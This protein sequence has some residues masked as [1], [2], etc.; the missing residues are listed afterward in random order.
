MTDKDELLQQQLYALENG[1]P[2]GSVV[3]GLPEQDQDLAPLISL[4]AA[5]REIPHPDLLLEQSQAQQQQIAA[6]VARPSNNHRNTNPTRQKKTTWGRWGWTIVPALA[7]AGVVMLCFVA[8]LAGV[9]LWLGGPPNARAATLMDAHGQIEVASSAVS[10]DWRSVTTGERVRAGQRLR[11]HDASG[12]TLLFFD[13]TRTTVGSDADVTLTKLGGGWGNVLKVTLTQNG[14][15]TNHSVVPLRGKNSSFL[16]LTPSGS[17]S[18]H[19]TTFNVDV[20]SNGRSRF[21]V[22]TGTVLVSNADAQVS[23][24]AGQATAAQ[25]GQKPEKPAYRFSLAGLVTAN[26]GTTWVVSGVPFTVTPDTEIRGNPQVSSRV[27]VKGRILES[28]VWVADQIEPVEDDQQASSFT[29]TV[30]AISGDTWQVDGWTVLANRITD[31]GEN[32]SVGRAVRVTFTILPD[33]RW[34]A[35]RIE[36]LE[37]TPPEPTSTPAPTPDPNAKPSLSFQPD[38]LEITGCGTDFSVNGA[39]VNEAE[40]AKDVAANVQLGYEVIKGA[41]SLVELN[42][43]SW[44]V[45]AAGQTVNFTLHVTLA[46]G[47]QVK[48]RVFVLHETNRP[49]HLRSRLTVTINSSCN[50]T[51]TPEGTETPEASKTPTPTPT[52]TAVVTGTMTPTPDFTPTL[53]PEPSGTPL[54]TATGVTNCTGANPQPKGMSLAQEFGVPYEVIMGWF[55]QGFGFG[56][57]DLAYSL[58]R[59]AGVPVT[60]IFEMRR[61][62]LGWGEIKQQLSPKPTKGNPQ[63]TKGNPHK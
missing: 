51:E 61:S 62:G 55:C 14:G 60:S 39:L 42:P 21:A 18:V 12:A 56:E 45:I 29:G 43:V 41:A 13:G 38:E 25:P 58:S 16:V 24:T 4:V 3:D 5:V 31:L 19:G 30:Q 36:S 33:G 1:A 47:Q 15:I 52:A 37:E 53:T 54:P 40:E 49:D 28:G 46:E 6:A 34:L 2:L 20:A 10:N 35:V 7:L 32:L 63:P 17:A 57:I 23:L 27:Q 50:Q 11:T 48:V 8:A 59:E 22:D 9:G 26:Q 44:D